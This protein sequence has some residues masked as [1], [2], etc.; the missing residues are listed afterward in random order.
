MDKEELDKVRAQSDEVIKGVMAL[1]EQ[2][3]RYK[4]GADYFEAATGVLLKN[5]EGEKEVVEEVQK[6]IEALSRTNL[7]KSTEMMG[8]ILEK[9]EDIK[10]EFC[11]IEKKTS[12]QQKEEKK[13]E[14]EIRGLRV[15]ME[16]LRELLTENKEKKG[17]LGIFKR[18]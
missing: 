14:K 16:E 5:A 1:K 12:V 8:E 18:R 6:Y 17:I 15:E 9:L 2:M 7:K 11:E 10:D 13:L 4:N 3:E